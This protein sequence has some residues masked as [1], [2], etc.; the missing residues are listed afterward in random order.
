MKKRILP[1]ITTLLCVAILFAACGSAANNTPN[2]SETNNPSSNEASPTGTEKK[3]TIKI[4]NMQDLSG[5]T[6]ESGTANTWGAEYMVRL[7]NEAGGING[8]EVELITLDT[9]NDTQ[10]AINCFNMFVDEYDVD[11]IIGP[12]VSNIAVAIAPLCQEVEIPMVGH[13]VDPRATTDEVTG[14]AWDY[15]FLIAPLAAQHGETMA[16]YAIKRLGAKTAACLYDEG[17][18]FAYTTALPFL[19]Y[20]EANGLSVVAAEKFQ[21]TDADYRAQAG[22]IVAANPDVVYLPNYAKQNVLAYD[23]LRQAGY[24]GIILGATT[25]QFP[26]TDLISTEL[27]DLHFLQVADMGNPDTDLY[28]V[29][30]IFM[31]ETNTKYQKVN[32]AYGYDSVCVIADA[33]ARCKDVHDGAELAS[34]I[35]TCKDVKTLS[36]VVTMDP[37]THVVDNAPLYI[38]VYDENKEYKVVEEY[39]LK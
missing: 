13:Y 6:S 24:K 2:P 15:M 37:N 32:V 16:D 5:S 26:F 4:G 17:N 30:E 19:E 27:H 35:E 14:K 33:L 28:K 36:G 38:T 20:A 10:Q 23:Q 1:L 11:V 25:C 39:Y 21:S 31:K 7:I 8:C 3:D 12:P 22:K 18:S 34:M 29:E 9:K